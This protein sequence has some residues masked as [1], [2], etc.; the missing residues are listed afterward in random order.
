MQKN[1]NKQHLQGESLK[2]T[3]AIQLVGKRE[4]WDETLG[5]LPA[6]LGL[7][8]FCRQDL[9]LPSPKTTPHILPGLMVMQWCSKT[10]VSC[11]QGFTL[12]D[13][14][15]PSLLLQPVFLHT[16]TAPLCLAIR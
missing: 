7:L 6:T 12:A 13:A 14:L 5:L 9:L 16:D 11:T 15:C 8:R 10:P 4:G 2:V 1:H 3:P